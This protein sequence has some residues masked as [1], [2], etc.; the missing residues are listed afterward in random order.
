MEG[1][2]GTREKLSEHLSQEELRM[3]GRQFLK[4]DRFVAKELGFIYL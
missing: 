4:V 1:F 2:W 3:R